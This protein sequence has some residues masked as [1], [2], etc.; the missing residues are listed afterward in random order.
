MLLFVVVD[1][2]LMMSAGWC[3]SFGAVVCYSL[4]LRLL[5]F[6]VWCWCYLRFVVCLL[7]LVGVVCLLLLFVLGNFL[8][9]VVWCCLLRVGVAVCWCCLLLV[10]VVDVSCLLL[11]VVCCVAAVV[12]GCRLLFGGVCR[13]SLWLVVVCCSLFVV[14]C[15]Y[16]LFVLSLACAV[17]C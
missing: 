17:R 4:L 7:L 8:F 6:V 13:W 2:C 15:R 14:C 16:V 12:V 1:C 9:V 3:V 11:R 5:L 10:F